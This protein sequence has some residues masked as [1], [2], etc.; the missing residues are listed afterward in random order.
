MLDL[1]LKNIKRRRTRTFLTT[2]GILIGITAI[3][4]L[5][6]F[7]EGLRVMVGDQLG[8]FA[9]KAV[10][11]EAG[12][13]ML[14][15]YA[16]SDIAQEQIDML[17]NMPGVDD[18]APMIF[19]IPPFGPGAGLPQY[20]IIGISPGDLE[21][22][23]GRQ[24]KAED[25]RLMEEGE[26]GVAVIGMKTADNLG[27]D[28]GDIY[29]FRESDF[30]IVGILEETGITDVEMGIM[31]PI[32]D[33]QDALGKDTYQIAYV[34]LEDPD[35]A[36]DFAEQVEDADDTLSA[37]TFKDIAR[38]VSSILGQIGIFTFGVGAI[39]AL[40]GGLGVLN[41]MIMAVAER[42]REIGVMKAVGATR[43]YVLA[44]ILLESAMISMMGGLGGLFLGWLASFGMG[45]ITGGFITAMVTPGLAAL[46]I[47][48]ALSLG[49]IGG[50]YPAWRAS[51]LDP[52]DAL[53][54]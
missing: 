53:R 26:S 6:S 2:L 14:S 15:G 20:Q 16:S 18:V 25:G 40:V 13:D 22:L 45:A 35:S 30:E 11:M 4:A 37:L 48:F 52:V 31:V 7:S 32:D 33:M 3:V 54:G 12:L 38:Q 43:R 10:V 5:G 29:S 23:I 42:K 49:I 27:L 8:E 9:G 39:A 21:V 1:A 36:E 44:Q 41:T 24:I 50:I 34:V 19:Y 28:V 47:V 46:S 51:R 17:S